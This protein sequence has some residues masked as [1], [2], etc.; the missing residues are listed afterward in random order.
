MKDKRKDKVNTLAR[1]N[2]STHEYEVGLDIEA[3]LS[4]KKATLRYTN[5]LVIEETKNDYLNSTQV[6]EKTRSYARNHQEYM[7]SDLAKEE[8]R[9]EARL[10]RRRAL[11]TIMFVGAIILAGVF[12]SLLLY[13]QSEMG[14]LSR[15]NSDAKDRISALRQQIVDAEEGVSGIT[16]MDVIRS[17]ALALGMQDP[18]ANQLVI[19]PMPGNDKLITVEAYD[20]DGISEE[21]LENSINNLAEYYR[22]NT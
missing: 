17:Q 11:Q 15:D 10:S 12:F 19:L 21:A 6:N 18:N 7:N 20:E 3:L 1:P 22:N 14:E 8:K 13:P 5:G 16:D 9:R 4:E 2:L